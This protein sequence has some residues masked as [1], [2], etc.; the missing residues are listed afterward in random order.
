MRLEELL[1][2]VFGEKVSWIAAALN[3][4]QLEVMRP[5]AVLNPQVRDRHV[6]DAAY[7]SSAT[8]ADGGTAVVEYLGRP[9]LLQLRSAYVPGRAEVFEHPQSS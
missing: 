6:A 8:N 5:Q 2:E 4:C 7:A 9:V 1:V 3:L